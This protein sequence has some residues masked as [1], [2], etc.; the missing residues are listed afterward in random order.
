MTDHP[1]QRPVAQDLRDILQI[2]AARGSDFRWRR[3]GDG[4]LRWSFPEFPKIRP[5][6]PLLGAGKWVPTLH[7]LRGTL[8]ITC[9]SR[10]HYRAR[11]CRRGDILILYP[12]M[13]VAGS[14]FPVG[15]RVSTFRLS[16]GQ[17]P[18]GLNGRVER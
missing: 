8:S 3:G 11:Y 14:A 7:E 6:Y 1:Y 10:P 12:R 4:A 5:G 16:A 17:N 18:A 15:V 9:A 13:L 2:S